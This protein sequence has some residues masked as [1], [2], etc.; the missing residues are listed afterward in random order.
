[1][2]PFASLKPEQFPPDAARRR[3][4]KGGSEDNYGQ[5]FNVFQHC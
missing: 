5:M 3:P 2:R 1:L 4:Y